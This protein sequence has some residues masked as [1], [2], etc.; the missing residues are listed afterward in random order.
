MDVRT[1]ARREW[2]EE[3][4]LVRRTLIVGGLVVL[5][6]LVWRIVD[7]F[8]L[9][10]GAIVVAVLLRA[11]AAA[12][13][14]RTLLS[15]GWSLAVA[16]LLVATVGLLALVLFGSE[17]SAQLADLS[18]RVSGIV[19]GLE[20]RFGAQG[21]G[22]RALQEISRVGGSG[23]LSNVAGVAATLVGG[24][25]NLVLVVFGGVYLA[26]E[27][28]LYRDG[29]VKLVPQAHREQVAETMEAA[30]N[31]LRLWLLGQL[32]AMVIVGVL[33]TLGLW[34][35]GMPSVL[36]L[37]LLA[38]ITN[39]VPFVGPVIAA[40]PAL[41]IALAEGGTMVLWALALYVL[42]QQ[43]EGNLITPMIERKAVSVPPAL[44]LF[45][46][47]AL[48]LLFGPLG[49]VLGAPLTVVAYV[50]I[51]KLYVRETLG[52]PTKVPGE[53]AGAPA[54]SS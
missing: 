8:L 54:G 17:V 45:A 53:E 30:G 18:Q 31:A 23:V 22:D 42:I 14:R 19:R 27:P 50:A 49:V 52:E 46:I 10:F 16:G 47:V 20:E 28:R 32:A 29:A 24:L 34:V 41:L 15:T 26:A 3:A 5:A 21:A 25:A 39:F 12:I 33:T 2:A 1:Q 37:G 13:A 9:A 7:V 43:I 38:G 51:K 36:A 6:L 48:G 40:V 11:L 44:V 35:I 4:A